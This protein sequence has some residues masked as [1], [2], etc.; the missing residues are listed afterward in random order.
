MIQCAASSNGGYRVKSDTA[1][2]VVLVVGVLY[3]AYH[4]GLWAQSAV[5]GSL[6]L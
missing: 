6:P 2:A 3:L 5:V 4:I 1:I